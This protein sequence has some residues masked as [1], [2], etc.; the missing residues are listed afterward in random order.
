MYKQEVV[1]STLAQRKQ[2][3]IS[4]DVQLRSHSKRWERTQT[5]PDYKTLALNKDA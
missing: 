4:Q 3:Q 1:I 2:A 5:Q